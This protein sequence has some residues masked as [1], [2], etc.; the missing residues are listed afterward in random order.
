MRPLV[1]KPETEVTAVAD[2]IEFALQAPITGMLPAIPGQPDA[3]S[4]YQR[5][6]EDLQK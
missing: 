5:L 2:A 3:V 1:E 4:D 6:L